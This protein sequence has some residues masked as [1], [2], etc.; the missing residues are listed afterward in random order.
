MEEE[1]DDVIE[2]LIDSKM[3]SANLN[4]RLDLEK[5]KVWK[6]KRRLQKYSV[7]VGYMELKSVLKELDKDDNEITKV[8][9]RRGWGSRPG[10][11]VSMF[12]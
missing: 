2:D 1:M 6:L 4:I 10:I 12:N 9:V 8:G 11:A 5:E 7:V 3:L